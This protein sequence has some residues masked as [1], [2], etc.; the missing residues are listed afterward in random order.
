[1]VDD[2][3]RIRAAD[4]KRVADHRPL[5]LAV[6]AEHLAQIV[7]ETGQHEPVW[8]TVGANRFGRLQQM[9]E[10]A[11]AMSGSESSTSVLR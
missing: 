5:R 10:L 4:G 6:E 2:L 3:R 1:M 11:S 8:M 9:F 7:H